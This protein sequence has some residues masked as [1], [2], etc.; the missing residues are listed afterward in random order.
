[1]RKLSYLLEKKEINTHFEEILINFLI[2]FVLFITI[3]LLIKLYFLKTYISSPL[4]KL[5]QYAYYHSFIPKA[6]KIKELEAI[7]HSMVDSFTRLE[8]EKETLYH[9]ARTDSLSG[10]A[11]RNS[12][13]EFLDRNIPIAKR[14]KEEFAYLFI[15]ID[16]FKEVNDSLGH[17]VGDELLKTISDKIK[18]IIRPTDF[19]ARVGGD[20]EW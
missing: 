16:H 17:N 7:R 15:D 6:F 1:M 9:M 8:E 13:D 14:S 5:R 10:L 12:L 3:A 4:E 19:I 11:N 18:N 20:V 2:N